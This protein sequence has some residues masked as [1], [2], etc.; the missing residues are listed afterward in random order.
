LLA[1]NIS[2]SFLLYGSAPSFLLYGSD[3]P[4]I[5]APP[6]DPAFDAITT[7]PF[8]NDAQK[9]AMRSENV[10]RLFEGKVDI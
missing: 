5:P 1:Y 8:L 9:L 3:W 10:K 6:V 2:P 4:W 7:S